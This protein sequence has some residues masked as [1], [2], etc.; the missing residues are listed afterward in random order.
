LVDRFIGERAALGHDPDAPFLADVAGD[1]ADLGFPGRNEARAVRA[2]Q[3]RR[4]PILEKRHR[5]HHVQRRNTFRDA[6]DERE[7]G[8]GGFHHGVGRE[9]RRDENDRHVGAGLLDGVLHGVEHRPA[10]VRGA[11]FAGRD[12]AHDGG[13]IR[14]RL[15]GVKR[16]FAAGQALHNQTRRFID[17]NSHSFQ[18]RPRKHEIPR[19]TRRRLI[20]VFL[21][22]NLVFCCFSL[23]RVLRTLRVFV[24]A[25]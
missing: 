9:L 24:V 11:A 25:F 12:A 3:A 14:R 15:L 10:L 22:T 17:Q 23:L 4:G 7:A 18:R 8:V 5:A 20:F 13:S 21:K 2:D 19:R 1:D 16:P 6:D